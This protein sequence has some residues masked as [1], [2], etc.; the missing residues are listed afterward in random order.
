MEQAA[1]RPLDKLSGL[2]GIDLYECGQDWDLLCADPDRVEEFCDIYERESL[3]EFDKRELMRFIVASYDEAIDRGTASEFV[4]QR[5]ARLLESDFFIHKE[6][7]EYWSLLEDNVN[8]FPIT[9]AMR[10][11][12]RISNN[13]EI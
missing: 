6:V 11:V 7:V 12:W 2:L 1:S 3:G 4:W 10:E 9:L 8:V 13:G 5:I